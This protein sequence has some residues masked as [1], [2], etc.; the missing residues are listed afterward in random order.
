MNWKLLP[1][2]ALAL[3]VS[4]CL[5]TKTP[6]IKSERLIVVAPPD[7]LYRCDLIK[8]LPDASTLTE[9]QVARLIARLYKD[10]KT[11]KLSMDALRK[12]IQKAKST[13]K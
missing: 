2:V 7:N 6:V 4:G 10:N 12:H 1:V 8:E 3:L 11:C 13:I 5:H 9:T